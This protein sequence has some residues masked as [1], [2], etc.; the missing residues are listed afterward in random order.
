[1][2]WL[3]P[4]H[5]KSERWV[6]Y[7]NFLQVRV[8]LWLKCSGWRMIFFTNRRGLWALTLW[9]VRMICLEPSHPK[10]GGWLLCRCFIWVSSKFWNTFMGATTTCW[11]PNHCLDIGS[12]SNNLTGTIP[13]AIG[14]MAALWDCRLGESFKTTTRKTNLAKRHKTQCSHFGILSKPSRQQRL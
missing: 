13:S 3:E 1:M 6:L 11:I 9:Q 8:T 5:R 12:D 7:C 14:D 10:L 4:Y 2:R